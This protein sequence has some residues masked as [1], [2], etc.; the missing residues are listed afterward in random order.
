VL[1]EKSNGIHACL[2]PSDLV[3]IEVK[4]NEI[5]LAFGFES[6]IHAWNMARG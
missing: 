6:H 1:V 3:G 5:W 2:G 4:V